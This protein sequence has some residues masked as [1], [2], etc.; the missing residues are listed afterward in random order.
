MTGAANNETPGTGGDQGSRPPQ[1]DV[2]QPD[3]GTQ[4]VAVL[5]EDGHHRPR[6]SGRLWFTHAR[7]DPPDLGA[8]AK[9]AVISFLHDA[10]AATADRAAAR[11]ETAGPGTSAAATVETGP[12]QADE[13]QADGIQADGISVA[14][15]PQFGQTQFGQTGADASRAEAESVAWRAASVG[16]ATLDRIEAA[17]ASIEA[18]IRAALQKQAELQAGAGAAA[19]TAVRAAASAWQAE[20]RAVEAE[21]R[22]K[23]AVRRVEHFVTITVILLIIA[24]I[25]VVVGATPLG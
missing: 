9:E 24:M 10:S 25:L 15:E 3:Q 16:L 4:R 23:V 21:G 12:G 14:D 19:E 11:A 2:I 13:I 17:A 22:V 6:S 20:G 8:L 18:D 5:P 7:P 1:T